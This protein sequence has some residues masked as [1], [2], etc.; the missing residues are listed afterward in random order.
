[1]EFVL[2]KNSLVELDVFFYKRGFIN[3]QR[4]TISLLKID[5][6]KQAIPLYHIGFKNNMG[7]LSSNQIISGM[8]VFEILDGYPLQSLLFINNDKEGTTYQQSIEELEAMDLY[9]VQKKNQDPYGDFVL[10]NVKFIDTKMSQS[11]EEFSRRMIAT[12]V[13][14]SKIPFRIPYFFNHFKSDNYSTHILRSADEV[15]QIEEDL[16]I[17]WGKLPTEKQ[18]ECLI[19]L[20]GKN[21]MSFAQK[22]SDYDI[23][24]EKI[25][26]ELNK[27]WKEHVAGILL[28]KALKKSSP[29]YRL[30]EFIYTYYKYA[31]AYN[32]HNAKARGDLEFLQFIKLGNEALLSNLGIDSASLEDAKLFDNVKKQ[33][34]STIDSSIKPYVAEILDN[35]FDD[36]HKN[37]KNRP[38]FDSVKEPKNEPFMPKVSELE[39]LKAFAKEL[40]ESKAGDSAVN[41]RSKNSKSKLKLYIQSQLGHSNPELKK[42]QK[43]LEQIS[44]EIYDS[45]SKTNG[46]SD[47]FKNVG[48]IQSFRDALNRT[49]I[50]NGDPMLDEIY[51][52]FENEYHKNIIHNLHRELAYNPK[53]RD[54]L[55]KHK[56]D[57]NIPTKQNDNAKPSVDK[58]PVSRD[59]LEKYR[60]IYGTK[61]KNLSP[62]E[63]RKFLSSLYS[64]YTHD[65]P[66]PKDFNTFI[67]MITLD[68][69]YRSLLSDDLDTYFNYIQ[70]IGKQ[71]TISEIKIFLNS[72]NLKVDE[73]EKFI[74]N[75][76]HKYKQTHA[77]K[78]FED[79]KREVGE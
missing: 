68:A 37:K 63:K 26:E 49:S 38:S 40:A 73:K 65:S 69:N 67:R 50:Q 42:D 71:T 13:A 18:I 64:A 53:I 23:P 74:L 32:Y 44:N 75:A 36:N 51:A 5:S 78:T 41:N 59:A 22:S 52:E 14:E 47:S 45:L 25:I 3:I 29:I 31:N 2:T 19:K 20:T 15:K 57:I 61:G 62:S 58:H 43:R 70:K 7:Y 30:K 79:F 77:D 21:R 76:Y 24:I 39:K 11:T 27:A 33:E 34:L 8:M 9:V 35:E 17:T 12:F 46:N 6:S 66:H 10:K 1:M 28:R 54:I 4:P 48:E 56:I 72:S 16:K 60:K 55:K